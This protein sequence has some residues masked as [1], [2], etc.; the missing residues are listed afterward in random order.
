MRPDWVDDR[1]EQL[2]FEDRL[3]GVLEPVDADDLDLILH[4]GASTTL[5]AASAMSSLVEEAAH[6]VRDSA[7]AGPARGWR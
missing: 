6:D 5:R 1:G 4:A 7:A 2:V 3:A